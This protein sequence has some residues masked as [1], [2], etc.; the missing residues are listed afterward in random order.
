MYK[1]DLIT[2]EITFDPLYEAWI[3]L[4]VSQNK[5]QS[6]YPSTHSISRGQFQVHLPAPSLQEKGL[7]RWPLGAVPLQAQ[8][9]L[10]PQDHKGQYLSSSHYRDS[11][12]DQLEDSSE[13]QLRKTRAQ[14]IFNKASPNIINANTREGQEMVGTLPQTTVTNYTSS[15]QSQKQWCQTVFTCPNF[16]NT[17]SCT[18]RTQEKNNQN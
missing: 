16:K 11:E 8:H 4:F 17:R 7:S 6:N 18:L 9:D 13:P 3:Q 15:E 5:P 2:E 1:A 10:R 12:Q 14:F